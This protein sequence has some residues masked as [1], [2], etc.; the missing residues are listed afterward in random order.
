MAD[1]EV[2]SALATCESILIDGANGVTSAPRAHFP[3]AGL[4]LA[5]AI[6]VAV[7]VRLVRRPAVAVALLALGSLPGLVHVLVLRADAPFARVAMTDSIKVT[8]DDLQTR[9]PWPQSQVTVVREEDDVLFPLGRYAL[10]S[11][12]RGP[13]ELVI[14]AG[15]MGQTCQRES[16]RVTCGVTP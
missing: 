15:P 14:G 3:Q 9:V 8:L 13:L 16:Q 4:W 11:R 7:V 2:T 10:P 12:T 6:A 5:V 1:P